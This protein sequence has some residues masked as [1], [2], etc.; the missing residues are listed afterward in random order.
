MKWVDRQQQLVAD[1]EARIREAQA[2]RDADARAMANTF[3][4]RL[5]P[6]LRRRQRVREP[7]RN[8]P[9][10]VRR[11]VMSVNVYMIPRKR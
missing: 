7:A 8:T 5:A 3:K 11:E 9:E 6:R 2:R 4:T 10:M 1:S